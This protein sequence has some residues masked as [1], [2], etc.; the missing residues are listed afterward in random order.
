LQRLPDNVIRT[1]S[2]PFSNISKNVFNA[3]RAKPLN[4]SHRLRA[5]VL[6]KTTWFW[7]AEGFER[8][9]DVTTVR[10]CLV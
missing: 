5:Y 2:P 4:L 9:E 10:L 7:K 6:S 3:S 8:N 1:L